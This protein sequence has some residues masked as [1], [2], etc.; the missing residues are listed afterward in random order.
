[1]KQAHK[2]LLVAA[3]VAVMGLSASAQTPPAPGAGQGQSPGYSQGA[4]RGP[5][6][7]MG[8]DPAR[9]QQRIERM[10]ER[11]AQRLAA[12]KQ[13]LQITPAQEGAWNAWT[14]ALKPAAGS[15]PRPDR[16]EMA[17]LTT[18]ERIDR[19]RALR[20]SR[21]AEMDRR[22]DATKTF[23]AALSPEQQKTFDTAT[24]RTGKRGMRGH[25]GGGW[26]H[27]RGA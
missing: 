19:M 12:F 10:Q 6:P 4:G 17:R 8:S 20:A 1:M 3:C 21:A 22:G 16:A 7:M 15:V 27:H 13:R 14:A 9:M 24:A 25:H 2:H 5:G 26:F 23:Y 11:M 18:P